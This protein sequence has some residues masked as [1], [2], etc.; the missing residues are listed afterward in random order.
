MWDAVILLQWW[1]DG[2]QVLAGKMAT[3]VAV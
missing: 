1:R 2:K 3:R